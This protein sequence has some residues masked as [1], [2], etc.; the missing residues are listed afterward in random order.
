MVEKKLILAAFVT[1]TLASCSCGREN[2]SFSFNKSSQTSIQ[3]RPERGF[4]RIEINGSPT[5]YYQQADSFSVKVKG[6]TEIIDR[7]ITDVSSGTLT[8]RNRGKVGLFNVSSGGDNQLS[9]F[10]TSPDLIG[11]RLHGS[12]D[13][14]SRHHVDTDKMNVVLKGSGDILFN[15]IICDVCDIELVGSGDV[16]IKQ[17]DSRSTNA[18]LVG[19]GDIEIRQ[20]NATNTRLSLRGSGDIDVDFGDNCRTAVAELQ[21]SGDIGLSGRV[22]QLKK[23]K[24][25][26]GSI[27]TGK[28]QVGN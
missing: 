11:V 28:L 2:M 22:Q 23:Q 16:D 14:I 25:G 9:V 17:L 4:E 12:G 6:P 20:K 27:Q 15:D 1:V 26:S 5:V 19:S 10:V 3:Y 21:G 13:F 7:I 8:I 18:S 24:S